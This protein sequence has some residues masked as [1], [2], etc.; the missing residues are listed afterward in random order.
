MA[1]FLGIDMGTSYFKAALFN[2]KGE[3]K[4]LGRKPVRKSTMNNQEHELPV[5]VFWSTLK[6]CIGE[7]IGMAKCNPGDIQAMSYSS[8]ANSFLLLDG[9]NE[10]LTPI[11]LWIDARVR[12]LNTSL[13]RLS[14]RNDFT[15]ITGIGSSLSPQM[16]I[17]KAMWFQEHQ[18]LL[19]QRV[20]KVM[21]ISD[22]LTFALTNETATDFST[23]SLTGL[24]N[25]Q[26]G[27]WWNQALEAASLAQSFLSV[28]GRTGTL[29]GH[30]TKPGAEKLGL[31]EGTRFCLGGLD[32]HV[33]AIGAGLCQSINI[34]ES[35]GTVLAS[36]SYANRYLPKKNVFMARGLDEGHFFQLN[37]DENG[38]GAL[39]W[40]Q[41]SQAPELSITELLEKAAAIE[42]G[43]AGLMARPCAS[44]YNDLE[45]FYNQKPDHGHGHYVRAILESTALSLKEI[46]EEL[47]PAAAYKR[48]VS[49]GG[50]AMSRLWVQIKADLLGKEFFIPQCN[51]SACL[52]AAMLAATSV[53]YFPTIQEASSQWV[54]RKEI[55]QPDWV[56]HD[57]YS[58]WTEQIK[59]M[60]AV[61]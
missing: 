16:C 25:I 49:T 37:Y 31:S 4:G 20:K 1:L 6:E 29:V 7:A 47:I 13:Q 5:P 57:F 18:P 40:Y 3:L 44:N 2:E 32:H 8:Q 55:V 34:S 39:E 56:N 43:S 26:E 33:A 24:L 19:W 17:A 21:T 11:I 38:A 52:G 36:V 9:K 53:H 60:N 15:A 46:I 41:K 58:R 23:T 35:T 30:I 51:E 27:Q 10:P 54:Q 22:Y 61:S 59:Q 48:V 42:P 45:G 28:P 50:G 14:Y 12:K